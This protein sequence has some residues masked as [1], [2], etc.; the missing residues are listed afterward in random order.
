MGYLIRRID[1]ADAENLRRIRLRALLSD[2]GV[3]DSDYE[4][5]CELPPDHW[6]RQANEASTGEHHCLFVVDGPEGLVG[7]AGAYTP[8]DQT[9][10]RRIY[11]MW[12]APESRFAGLG[13]QLIAAITIWSVSAGADELQ[14]WVV[15][16]NLGAQRLYARAG[17]RSTGLSQ[18]LPSNPAVTETLLHLRLG[19]PFSPQG[20]A[21]AEDGGGPL[22]PTGGG[23]RG[24]NADP[25]DLG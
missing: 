13:Q 3:F 14:L 17:F 5:E 20:G 15:D 22:Y 12:V 8:G 2:P 23:C 11:G 18:A 24:G 21:E 6:T 9:S 25:A 1:P 10:V 7:M 16:H 19:S 4:R